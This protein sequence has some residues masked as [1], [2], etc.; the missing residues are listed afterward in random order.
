MAVCVL[1]HICFSLFQPSLCLLYKNFAMECWIAFKQLLES[2]QKHRL[3]LISKT[4]DLVQL[5]NKQTFLTAEKLAD[6]GTTS[7]KSSRMLLQLD[8]QISDASISL[9]EELCTVLSSIKGVKSCVLALPKDGKI[10]CEFLSTFMCDMEQ[11]HNLEYRI[12]DSIVCYTASEIDQDSLTTMI[13]CFEYP[14]YMSD[15]RMDA[16]I[17]SL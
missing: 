9:R 11:Q 5:R 3:K 7:V 17:S 10:D 2:H 8:D 1:L 16:L 15:S 12:V 4:Q 14:P 13:A 6:A